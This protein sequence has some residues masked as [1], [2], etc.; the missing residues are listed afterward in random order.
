MIIIIMI[1]IIMIIN[2]YLYYEYI[3][4]MHT[5]TQTLLYLAPFLHVHWVARWLSRGWRPIG[6]SMKASF[7]ERLLTLKTSPAQMHSAEIPTLT[8]PLTPQVF[9]IQRTFL[10]LQK[11]LLPFSP[12]LDSCIASVRKMRMSIKPGK[13]LVHEANSCPPA[14]LGEVH[15]AAREDSDYPLKWRNTLLQ[16]HSEV[17]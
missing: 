14:F 15:K 6:M 9:P 10:W 12:R 1:I 8:K 3:I 7:P 13:S 4:L 11:P 5:H 16:K 17:F 2:T